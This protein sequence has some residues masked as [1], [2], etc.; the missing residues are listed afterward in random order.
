MNMVSLYH[1][2]ES[3]R[4]QMFSDQLI[5]CAQMVSKAGAAKSIYHLIPI[6]VR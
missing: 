4:T 1:G 6:D 3:P 2:I 5:G